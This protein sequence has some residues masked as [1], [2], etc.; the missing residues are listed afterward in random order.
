MA[1]KPTEAKKIIPDEELRRLVITAA[2]NSPGLVPS[3]KAEAFL[4]DQSSKPEH[5]RLSKAQKNWMLKIAESLL[6]DIPE[7]LR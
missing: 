4:I 5:W 3:S 7:R 2:V 1:D 6:L